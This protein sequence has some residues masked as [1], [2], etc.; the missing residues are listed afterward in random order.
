MQAAGAG[1]AWVRRCPS[2]STST[3]SGGRWGS[4]ACAMVLAG[5]PGG[6]WVQIRPSSERG[7]GK[8]LGGQRLRSKRWLRGLEA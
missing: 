2:G 8:H 4:R 3:C 1:I 5:A 7:C 6:M